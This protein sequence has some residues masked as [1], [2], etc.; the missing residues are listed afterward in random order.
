MPR[1]ARIKIDGGGAFYHLYCRTA[2]PKGEYPLDSPLVRRK[3]ISL[4]EHYSRVYCCR[5]L[6]FCIMGNHYHLVVWFDE[7]RK[8][9]R[10]ELFER[11][12]LLYSKTLLEGWLRDSWKRFEERIFDVS[13]FMR[14]FQAAAARWYNYTFSR[15]GRF[16]AERFKSTLLEDE[17]QVMDCLLYVELNA[18][19]A[20]IATH[21]EDYEGASVYYRDLSKDKWMMP[22]QHLVGQEKRGMA[23]R[24]YKAMIYYRGNVSTKAGQKPIPNRI[25]EQEEA[26]DFKTKGIYRKRW[27]HFVD[28]VV[29]GSEAYVRKEIERL[30]EQGI[31]LRRKHPVEQLNGHHNSLREQRTLR[32]P[33]L[34]F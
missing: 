4:F 33:E 26:R 8:M 34:A 21:P 29:I 32:E 24:D 17:E 31:Y 22:L 23:L 16:W 27:R 6:G 3:I 13:E 9:S 19:R 14:N 7:R 12:R 28:G 18:V 5:I 2:G 25:V 10:D 20:G 15:R 11:A 1:L 30:R